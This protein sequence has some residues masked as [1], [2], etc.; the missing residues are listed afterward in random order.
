M[1]SKTRGQRN[2]G[3]EEQC[4]VD[5]GSGPYLKVD[6]RTRSR[7]STKLSIKGNRG[8]VIVAQPPPSGPGP[9]PWPYL[10]ALAAIVAVI[11]GLM[12]A[13]WFSPPVADGATVLLEAPREV[14][15][16]PSSETKQ[17]QPSTRRHLAGKSPKGRR[18]ASSERA[19]T[20]GGTAVT[21]ETTSPVA[22][23]ESAP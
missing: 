6:A 3:I 14:A 11:Y 8:T 23:L 22:P 19:R 20:T 1:T 21:V 12:R 17:R 10:I 9:G 2:V 13:G 4:Q 7:T 18:P 16:R 15:E 5:T